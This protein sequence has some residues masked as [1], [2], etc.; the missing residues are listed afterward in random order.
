MNANQI[1]I[2]PI[3]SEKSNTIREQDVK[4]YTF[5][6]SAS[7]NKHEIMDA[8]EELFNVK[9]VS[10]NTMFVKGKPKNSR[11]RN[12]TEGK[13]S[14]WKKAIVTMKKGDKITALEVL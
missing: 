12:R 7:A 9:P 11:T 10:C 8:V 14:S 1:I 3:L 13:R 6:V 2:A 5:K 4:K